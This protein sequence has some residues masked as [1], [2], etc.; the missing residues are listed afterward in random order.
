[1]RSKYRKEERNLLIITDLGEAIS[2]RYLTQRHRE[3]KE[4]ARRIKADTEETRALKDRLNGEAEI[5][6]LERE[7]L[8]ILQEAISR[9]HLTQRHRE[10]KE[11][12]RRI[13]ADT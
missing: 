9:R 1:M 6:G 4:K 13:K 5:S 8:L 10:H 7:V 12:A 11:K 2:R 3:H